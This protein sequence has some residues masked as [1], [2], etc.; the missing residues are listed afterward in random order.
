MTGLCEKVVVLEKRLLARKNRSSMTAIDLLKS[1]TLDLDHPTAHEALLTLLMTVGPVAIDAAI[2]TFRTG[3]QV[4]VLTWDL[5]Q[6][7]PL[8]R[9]EDVRWDLCLPVPLHDAPTKEWFVNETE[10]LLSL[11]GKKP[12]A[13]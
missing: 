2:Y 11:S 13:P 1:K 3:I 4:D 8:L 7:A 10:H 12:I 9:G 6:D 5:A